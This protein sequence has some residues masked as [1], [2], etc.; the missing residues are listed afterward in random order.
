MKYIYTIILLF[1]SAFALGQGYYD[2]E[3]NFEDTS[4]YFRINID[5]ISNPNNIW[6]IGE[7]QK[8]ILSYAYSTPNVIITD[9]IEFYPKN[10]T[11]TFSIMHICDIGFHYGHTVI[12][13]GYYMSDCDSLSDFGKIE[14]THDMGSTWINLIDDSVYSDYIDWATQK[15]ALTGHVPAWTYFNV[16][17]SELGPILNIEFE[18]TVYYKFTFISDSIENSK[19]GLMFDDLY[20][21]DSYQVIDEGSNSKLSVDVFPIPTSSMLT[22][23]IESIENS[24]ILLELF[25][26]NGKSILSTKYNDQDLININVESFQPGLYIFHITT[27]DTGRKA[28]GKFVVTQ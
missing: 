19:G 25:D 5:T 14:F 8:S 11:S 18:D 17:L 23:E 2:Y 1:S 3:I 6:Q 12:L 24:P 9:T 15:P 26:L 16:S 4:Q 27:I 10:D 22:F 20:F 13:A 21:E 28:T 7:P